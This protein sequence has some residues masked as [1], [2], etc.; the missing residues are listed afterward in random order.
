[1]YGCQMVAASS[2]GTGSS[3]TTFTAS[4]GLI[5]S[6]NYPQPY[7][8]NNDKYYE[9]IAPSFRTIKLQFLTFDVFESWEIYYCG[10]ENYLHVRVFCFRFY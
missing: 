9:I 7:P 1:M 4:S 3:A 10:Y 5:L 6:P 8:N 2:S